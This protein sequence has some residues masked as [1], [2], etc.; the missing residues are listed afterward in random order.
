MD[1]VFGNQRLSFES[2]ATDPYLTKLHG[3][4][5]DLASYFSILKANM[6]PDAVIVDVGANIG[7]SSLGASLL[8]PEGRVIACEP[9]PHNLKWLRKNIDS[10]AVS[11]VHVAPKA[12]GEAPGVVSFQEGNGA[13]D[14]IVSEQATAKGGLGTL[15]T[16]PIVTLDQFVHDENLRRID[17]IKVDVEGH[18][19]QVLKG[20]M[21]SI[22]RFNPLVYMEFN[23][24]TS[25][26]FANLNPRALLDYVRETFQRVFVAVNGLP[27]RE[28]A[29]D[30]D[31]FVF[32][33]DN[34]TKYGC[35]ND[36]LLVPA[37]RDVA[38]PDN[39][40]PPFWRRAMT[41]FRRFLP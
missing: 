38:I 18:E 8:V 21:D 14:H 41:R 11:N 20:A 16:V 39:G 17:M 4:F 25:I 28:L 3:Y 13:G 27:L 33:H 36:L 40:R 15:I 24:W 19:L 35:V 12:F 30:Q 1:V 26:A 34:L 31:Y 37:G 10:N 29:N 6:P 9:G 32:L 22:G 2:E 7:L 23:S 5:G